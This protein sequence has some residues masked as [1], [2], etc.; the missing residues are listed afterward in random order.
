MSCRPIFLYIFHPPHTVVLH[1][2]I[3]HVYHA[4]MS[5]EER[6]LFFCAVGTA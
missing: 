1:Q 2:S 6:I 4:S 3:A 5:S